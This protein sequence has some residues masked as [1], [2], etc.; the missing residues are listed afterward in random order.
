MGTWFPGGDLVRTWFGGS[1]VGSLRDTGFTYARICCWVEPPR[2]V[3]IGEFGIRCFIVW[4]VLL[5]G[6]G[7]CLV[8]IIGH[9]YVYWGGRRA[10]ARPDGRQLGFSREDAQ[11]RWL[12]FRVRLLSQINYYSTLTGLPMFL[13]FIWGAMAWGLGPLG[14]CYWT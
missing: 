14:S 4:I 8:W 11:V 6:P 7:P 3:W 12:G 13:L 1:G 5:S 10:E 2:G 9:S